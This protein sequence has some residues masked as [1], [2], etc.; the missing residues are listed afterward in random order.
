M[1]KR[2]ALVAALLSLAA[3]IGWW[4][5]RRSE[6]QMVI[7]KLYV[8]NLTVSSNHQYASGDVILGAN[9]SPT[10]TIKLSS[11]HPS[12]VS[13]KQDTFALTAKGGTVNVVAALKEIRATTDITFT[14]TLN[15]KE[16]R[17]VTLRVLPTNYQ[18][19]PLDVVSTQID[20]NG[21]PLNPSWFSQ[22]T[23]PGTKGDDTGCND[24]CT[25]GSKPCTRTKMQYNDSWACGGHRNWFPV[26]YDSGRLSFDFSNIHRTKK[27]L[28]IT[29]SNETLDTDYCFAYDTPD[30]AGS[31]VGN[32]APMAPGMAGQIHC[33]FD[34]HEIADYFVSPFWSKLNS[35][36]VNTPATVQETSHG[37]TISTGDDL[38]RE[39]LFNKRAVVT[40]IF[41]IDCE[42]GVAELHPVYSMAVAVNDAEDAPLNG[43]TNDTWAMFWRNWGNQG[44]CGSADQQLESS[45]PFVTKLRWPQGATAVEVV[46]KEFWLSQTIW[47]FPVP[48]PR[49]A[50]VDVVVS[51]DDRLRD[52]VYV[53]FPLRPASEHVFI[54]GQITLHWTI[55]GATP[56]RK[57]RVVS[58][59]P[60]KP[61][62]DDEGEKLAGLLRGRN[63]DQLARFTAATQKFAGTLDKSTH[64]ELPPPARAGVRVEHTRVLPPTTAPTVKSVVSPLNQRRFDSFRE[65]VMGAYDGKVPPAIEQQ[66]RNPR[67]PAR[68]R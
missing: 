27:I 59:G 20:V 33:E 50:P 28:G 21:L 54:E 34:R 58:P 63:A 56:A 26:T 46:D 8:F 57:S 45:G 65:A 3:A 41:N 42:H 29:V 47:S 24:I 36:L 31:M 22:W 10:N 60:R 9:N 40:G 23:S 48:P 38:A 5:A 2:S 39:L 64:K 4:G 30:G 68:T 25:I 55:P 62:I 67:E 7:P 37:L 61:G 1:R 16:A 32:D 13:F 44:S 51:Y 17:S 6:A 43:P 35:L 66:R 19:L 15:G 14:A 11:D 53:S 49:G 18:G 12:I 52:G